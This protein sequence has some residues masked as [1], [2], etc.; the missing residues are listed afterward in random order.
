MLPREPDATVHLDVHLRVV[1]GRGE[2]QMRRHGRGEIELVERVGCGAGGVPH[3][4]GGQ[5]GR[6]EHVGAVVLDRLE[7]SDGPA[8]LHAL[9][10]VGDGH[11]RTG[12]HDA[13]GLGG[14]KCAHQGAGAAGRTGEHIGLGDPDGRGRGGG[15]SAGRVDVRRGAER[16]AI[17]VAP[18]DDHVVAGPQQQEIGALAAEHDPTVPVE[19]PP[20]EGQRAAE[21]DRCRHRTVGERWEV[22]GLL[23]GTPALRNH[24]RRQGGR[25][26]RTRR[27]LA[28]EL[29]ED[30]D[31]LVQ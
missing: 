18:H 13:G 23:L 25:Q 8:E 10:R 15:R 2:G 1:D 16:E 3:R 31:E 21:A 4:R 20:V 6:H 24:R 11:V 12:G 29:L 22:G 19:R 9:L 5:L 17:G 30:D 28:S 7:G 27:D 14:T 26:E